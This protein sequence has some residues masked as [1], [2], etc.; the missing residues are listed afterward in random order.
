MAPV[1]IV[2]FGEINPHLRTLPPS[3]RQPLTNKYSFEGKEEETVNLCGG[4]V[5]SL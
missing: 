2:S 1:V 4:E 3:P 5:P